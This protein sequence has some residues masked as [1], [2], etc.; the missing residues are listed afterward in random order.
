ME[1]ICKGV[2]DVGARVEKLRGPGVKDDLLTSILPGR[3]PCGNPA[4][5]SMACRPAAGI[6]GIFCTI[7]GLDDLGNAWYGVLTLEI[8]VNVGLLEAGLAGRDCPSLPNSSGGLS[9]GLLIFVLPELPAIR[10]LFLCVN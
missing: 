8:L 1:D 3:R 4:A 2:V 9:P 5:G 7:T 10:S 6:P